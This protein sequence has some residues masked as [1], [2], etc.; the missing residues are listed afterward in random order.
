MIYDRFDKNIKGEKTM[1]KFNLT[2][3][4]TITTLFVFGIIAF[5]ADTIAASNYASPTATPKKRVTSGNKIANTKVKSPRFVDGGVESV[6][7][8]DA[9]RKH[10]PRKHKN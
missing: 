8:W 10:R 4:A 9:R 2:V 6:D 3:I 1:K 7:N 5:Q